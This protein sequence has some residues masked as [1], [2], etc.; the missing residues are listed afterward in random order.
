MTIASLQ[1]EVAVIRTGSANIASVAAAL[2]RLGTIPHI[3]DSPELVVSAPLVILPGVGAFGP[4]MTYLRERGLDHAIRARVQHGRSLLAICLG[5]QLLC[6]SSEE[7]PGV[8]GLGLV[9]TEVRRIERAPHLPQLRVPQLRVPQ[10][11]V[12]QMGWNRLTPESRCSLLEP[13]WM[14]FAHSYRIESLPSDWA[15]ATTE[16]GGPFVAALE[17]G[18]LLACQFHPELS[19]RDGRSLLSRWLARASTNVEA[20]C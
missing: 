8:E 9:P 14:Y 16:Y 12:P 11:R 10:L 2:T 18:P 13:A 7:S 17:Q 15:V 5:M 3:T 6:E 19:G 1:P 20:E 4:A